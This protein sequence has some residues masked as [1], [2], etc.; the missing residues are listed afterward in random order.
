MRDTYDSGAEAETDRAQQKALLTALNGWDRALRRDEC[1]A[2]TITGSRGSIHSDGNA[3]LLYVRGRS[4][5]HWSAM[6]ARLSFCQLTQDGD[7]EGCLGLC[8]LPTP[9]QAESIRDALGI[10]KRREVSAT[11]LERLKA[12]A[13][14]R[15]LR[16]ETS[17][18]P[19]IGN[20]DLPRP[21]PT[22]DQTPIFSTE[23]RHEP[24]T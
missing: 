17:I 20:D 14:E 15:K 19:I 2:W 22:P 1:G 6:K 18:R 8:R 16:R 12:F 4:A 23:G 3:W 11:V 21:G 7:D 5:R 24:Q 10:R 9:A 13:F